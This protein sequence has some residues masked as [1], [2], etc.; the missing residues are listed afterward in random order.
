MIFELSVVIA[1][2]MSGCASDGQSRENRFQNRPRGAPTDLEVRF[3]EL[4]LVRDF[5]ELLDGD[6]ARL[7]ETLG[8]AHRVQPAIQQLLRLRVPSGAGSETGA[9]RRARRVC[10]MC[11]RLL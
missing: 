2:L 1:V 10:K 4:D 3:V 8:D 7:L 6:V 11:A 5:F 9:E